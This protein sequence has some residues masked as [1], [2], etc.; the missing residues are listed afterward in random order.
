M[1]KTEKLQKILANAG[2]ASRR[3]VEAMI[4]AGRVSVNGEIV[5]LGKRA[6]LTDKIRI[7]GKLLRLNP[8]KKTR[9]LIYNKPIGEV[10]TRS[11]EEG[12]PTVF[13][14]LPILRDSRWVSIGRLDINTTGLLLFTNDGELANELMH[15]RNV[16]EREYAVRVYGEVS[17]DIIRHL[18]EGVMLEDGEAKF[19][20]V[21]DAGGEG[22]NHWYH[23]VLTEGRNREVR[24]LWESQG[25]QVSRLI[26]IRYGNITLPK[27]VR[28]GRWHE[29]D[30][31]GIAKLKVSK[32]TSSSAVHEDLPKKP[33][34]AK[35][36]T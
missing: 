22:T 9:V 18:K 7:D 36:R 26:R 14:R 23:V 3:Q 21:T 24:R 12:R 29:L 11:D 25:V 19:L 5:E 16:V 30:A 27:Y 1:I 13:E 8:S 35:K 28:L 4:E 31:E 6:L 17:P 34:K 10:C 2:I 33:I 32:F 20:S 15:P